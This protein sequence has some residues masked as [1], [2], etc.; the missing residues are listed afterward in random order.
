LKQLSSIWYSGDRPRDRN[1]TPLLLLLLL[2]LLTATLL[3]L[4]VRLGTPATAAAAAC[5]SSFLRSDLRM[6]CFFCGTASWLSSRTLAAAAAAAVKD[7]AAARSTV[8][9]ATAGIGTVQQQHVKPLTM[10]CML[11]VAS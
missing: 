6:L 10:P 9:V 3:L 8:T 5:C 11:A 7:I 4:A 1:R 2:E